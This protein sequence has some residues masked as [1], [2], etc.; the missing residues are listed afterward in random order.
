[1]NS[2]LLSLDSVVQKGDYAIVTMERCGYLFDAVLVSDGHKTYLLHNLNARHGSAP[3]H[4]TMER[5]KYHYSW[6]T[7][8]SDVL[9]RSALKINDCGCDMVFKELIVDDSIEV[10]TSKGKRFYSAVEDDF[11]DSLMK[12]GYEKRKIYRGQ[13]GWHSHHGDYLNAPTKPNPEGYRFG[14]E[15]EVEF[16]YEDDLEAFNDVASNWFYRERDGSLDD[17]GCEIIT[18]PLLPSDAKNPEFWH[19]L[20]DRIDDYASTS[21]NC[22]LHI[23][24]SREI[25]GEESEQA[26]TLGK[27][28]YLYHHLIEETRMNRDVFGRDHGYHAYDGKTVEG[29]AIKLFGENLLLNENIKK[30][31]MHSVINRSNMERYFDI[32]ITNDATIEF[33]KGAGTTNPEKIAGMVEYCELMCLYA[34]K[35]RWN[36]ISFEGFKAY[37]TKQVKGDWLKQ[38]LQRY[39]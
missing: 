23:H 19:Q 25:L 29:N 37:L 8:S 34:R 10:L 13:G 5:F 4:D 33:R 36:K 9:L 20:V 2:R 30:K 3:A 31:V 18:V 11:D 28:L 39:L 32:N 21:S 26:D 7:G 15:M 17:Y 24:V 27:L 6:Y 14:I 38:K 16:E 35:T 1:M 12:D 22:G